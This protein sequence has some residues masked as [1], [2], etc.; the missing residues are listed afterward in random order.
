M[1]AK[2][3]K[4]AEVHHGWLTPDEKTGLY[5]SNEHKHSPSRPPK[6]YYYNCKKYSHLSKRWCQHETDD[7]IRTQDWD[8][9]YLKVCVHVH[10]QVHV[11]HPIVFYKMMQV[12]KASFWNIYIYLN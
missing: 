5:I 7:Q 11:N 2:K 1:N 9:M 6:L 8:F 4:S 3:T 10:V 12:I